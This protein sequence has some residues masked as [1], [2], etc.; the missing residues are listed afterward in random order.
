MCAQDT[1]FVIRC[2]YCALG[3]NFH[4]LTPRRDGQFVCEKCGHTARPGEIGY[5]CTCPKCLRLHDAA[6]RLENR[7]LR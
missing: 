2:P 7:Y 6:V 4:P 1:Q 3:W 5:L